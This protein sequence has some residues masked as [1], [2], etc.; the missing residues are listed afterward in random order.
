MVV[1]TPA[2]S[3]LTSGVCKE[4]KAL[5]SSGARR[6]NSVLAISVPGSGATGAWLLCGHNF[7]PEIL[8][9]Y[10]DLNSQISHHRV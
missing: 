3:R 6:V 1:K 7:W 8:S 5:A 9:Q 10:F 4:C 2:W